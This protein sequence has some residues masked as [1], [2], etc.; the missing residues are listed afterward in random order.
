MFTS[1]SN[2]FIS[3]PSMSF[4]FLVKFIPKYFI[5]FDVILNG[6]VIFIYFSRSLLLLCI[7]GTY[8]CIV[9]LYFA[10]LLNSLLRY[11]SFPVPSLGF[12]MYSFMS[13]ANS[14]SSTCFPIS[15]HFIY[16]SCLLLWLGLPI[17]C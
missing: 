2:S 12:S 16:L 8:I 3:F 11:I 10:T 15:V 4:I 1:Y 7:N 13:S 6:I 9:V 14:N 5:L 17:L